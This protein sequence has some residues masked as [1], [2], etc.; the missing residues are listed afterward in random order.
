M[1]W[2]SKIEPREFAL[3]L[4]FV[5]KPCHFD[6]EALR[7]GIG[8][9]NYFFWT[10]EARHGQNIGG[11]MAPLAPPLSPS[12]HCC[13]FIEKLLQKNCQK[14]KKNW[15]KKTMYYLPFR[16]SL[17]PTRITTHF[18]RKI[19]TSKIVLGWSEYYISFRRKGTQTIL[20]HGT[21]IVPRFKV[22]GGIACNTWNVDK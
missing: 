13:H 19:S 9:C 21:L 7:Q 20:L 1:H 18:T 6:I 14:G 16:S 10:F 2:L 22:Y 3:L 11:A 8:P 12:L 5:L 17:W 4:E 15:P